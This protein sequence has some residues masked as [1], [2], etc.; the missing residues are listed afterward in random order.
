MIRHNGEH[1]RL[2]GS[3]E[4]PAYLSERQ[5]GGR[6]AAMGQRPTR[7]VAGWSGVRMVRNNGRDG[8]LEWRKHDPL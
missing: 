3:E 7:P 5:V 2:V 1:S 6:V 4:G 8:L